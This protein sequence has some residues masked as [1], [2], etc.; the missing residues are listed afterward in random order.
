MLF[1]VRYFLE[2]Y[3]IW[4]GFKRLSLK[5][6]EDH[7]TSMVNDRAVDFVHRSYVFVQIPACFNSLPAAG[8]VNDCRLS[9]EAGKPCYSCICGVS[10][11]LCCRMWRPRK[12]KDGIKFTENCWM[13]S[14][15]NLFFRQDFQD[16]RAPVKWALTRSVWQPRR[17][18]IHSLYYKLVLTLI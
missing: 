7:W 18:N 17:L 6:A 16:I 10:N 12:L 8:F 15:F 5:G 11:A 14:V 13:D 1:A 3:Q 2:P 4:R 9:A